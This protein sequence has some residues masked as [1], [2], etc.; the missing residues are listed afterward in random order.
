[1]LI[2]ELQLPKLL[3]TGM[4]LHALETHMSHAGS[5]DET[6][7]KFYATA[8]TAHVDCQAAADNPCCGAHD[9]ACKLTLVSRDLGI[10]TLYTQMSAKMFATHNRVA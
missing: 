2:C 8:G 6:Y 4:N 9:C 3:L 5:I 7:S 10:H 1:M